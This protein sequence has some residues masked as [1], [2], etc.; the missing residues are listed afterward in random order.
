MKRHRTIRIKLP[1]PQQAKFLAEFFRAL[2]ENTILRRVET[3]LCSLNI[4]FYFTHD[5]F[6]PVS[7]GAL[8]PEVF[9]TFSKDKATDTYSVAFSTLQ[10]GTLNLG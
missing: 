10:E 5:S 8:I 1:Q 9:C 2:P 6:A 7:E 3:E 4:V